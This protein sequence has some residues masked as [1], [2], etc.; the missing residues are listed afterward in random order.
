[1]WCN[2]GC[3]SGLHRWTEEEVTEEL[4]LIAEKTQLDYD[5]GGKIQKVVK[6]LDK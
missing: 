3:K 1:V 4:V 5:N 6:K 2:G